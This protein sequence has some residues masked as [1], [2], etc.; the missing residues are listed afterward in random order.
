MG[1]SN[2]LYCIG[3]IAGVF[4]APYLFPMAYVVGKDGAVS[5]VFAGD[6]PG[7]TRSVIG[8]VFFFICAALPC[9]A[10]AP[11]LFPL[12]KQTLYFIVGFHTVLASGALLQ[13][14]EERRAHEQK[15]VLYGSALIVSALITVAL[16][17]A[18]IFVSGAYTYAV[19]VMVI[20]VSVLNG[21]LYLSKHTP[22][23]SAAQNEKPLFDVHNQIFRLVIVV[24]ILH[25]L[26]SVTNGSMFVFDNKA[27]EYASRNLRL[28]LFLAYPIGGFLGEKKPE[29]LLKYI[30]PVAAMFFLLSAALFL[31]GSL[32][33]DMFL[34]WNSIANFIM[35]GI[36]GATPFVF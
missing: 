5:W 28:A 27:N 1:E 29:W 18:G 15:G 13:H 25:T 34:V 19:C 8:R 6:C 20:C 14:P 2:L 4:V 22:V 7:K 3:T 21:V 24:M 10:L 9:L 26:N 31:F 33:Q 16:Q 11:A 36:F 30:F 35:F 32:R 12:L 17:A 23:P